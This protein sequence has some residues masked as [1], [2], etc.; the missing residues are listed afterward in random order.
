MDPIKMIFKWKAHKLTDTH[1]HRER[2]SDLELAWE[3]ATSEYNKRTHMFVCVAINSSNSKQNMH[4]IKIQRTSFKCKLFSICWN[5]VWSIWTGELFYVRPISSSHLNFSFSLSYHL[6]LHGVHTVVFCS[7]LCRTLL[8]SA[9]LRLCF[10]LLFCVS[11][12]VY[13]THIICVLYV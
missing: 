3:L 2:A 10:A 8:W 13:T 4:M 5:G 1:T 9:L 11:R 7:L 12:A 6:V